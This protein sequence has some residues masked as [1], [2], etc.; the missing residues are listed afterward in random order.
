MSLLSERQI[1]SLKLTRPGTCLL[2][3]VCRP[4]PI[5]VYFGLSSSVKGFWLCGVF[6][7]FLIVFRVLLLSS[8]LC[9]PPPAITATQGWVLKR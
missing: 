9:L 4:A 3:F 2:A 7:F 6:F 1:L 8:L 5:T